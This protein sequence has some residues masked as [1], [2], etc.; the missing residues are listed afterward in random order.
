[1]LLFFFVAD[2]LSAILN[3]GIDASEISPIK[4]CLR[5]LGIW[6]LLF[7]DDTLL[8]FKVNRD[9]GLRVKQA[10]GDKKKKP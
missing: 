1:L 3:K 6:H 7:A 9:Q 4:V 10:L 5:A 8:F 2:G